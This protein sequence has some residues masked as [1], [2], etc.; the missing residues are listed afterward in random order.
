MEVCFRFLLDLYTNGCYG[1]RFFCHSGEGH[2]TQEGGCCQLKSALALK[3]QN[4]MSFSTLQRNDMVACHVLYEG[5]VMDPTEQWCVPLSKSLFN[6]MQTCIIQWR[7]HVLSRVTSYRPPY[8]ITSKCI[9]WW[10]NVNV[11]TKISYRGLKWHLI[12]VYKNFCSC[13]Q[14]RKS[15]LLL[16]TSSKISKFLFFSAVSWLPV[17]RWLHLPSMLPLYVEM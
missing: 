16:S 3:D 4:F 6:H 5:S 9:G 2:S 17:R 1:K 15:L 10:L 7:W 13:S 12:L 8:V 11:F 14:F